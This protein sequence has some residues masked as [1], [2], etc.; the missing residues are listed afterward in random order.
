MIT[1]AQEKKKRKNRKNS[2]RT[3]DEGIVRRILKGIK[4]N[5]M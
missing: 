5:M 1:L 4:V 2:I 3:S